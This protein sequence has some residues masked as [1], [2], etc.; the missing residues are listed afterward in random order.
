M[1]K[2]LF[3]LFFTVLFLSSPVVLNAQNKGEVLHDFSIWKTEDDQVIKGDYVMIPRW[4]DYTLRSY[5]DYIFFNTVDGGLY[6]LKNND[7]SF[8]SQVS[9][10]KGEVLMVNED[11]YLSVKDKMFGSQGVPSFYDYQNHKIWT[12]KYSSVLLIEREHRVVCYQNKP[13]SNQ[14]NSYRAFNYSNGSEMWSFTLSHKYHYPWFEMKRYKD[15]PDDYYVIAD[16]LVKI[17]LKTG[18]TV[19]QPFQGGVV[20]PMKSRF[21]LV[22]NSNPSSSSAATE[23]YSSCF[24]DKCI[25]TGTHSQFLR[26]KDRLFIA[27]AKIVYCYDLDLNPIWKTALPEGYGANSHLKRIGDELELTCIGEAFEGGL[28]GRYGRVFSASYDLTSGKQKSLIVPAIS[29]KITAALSVKEGTYWQS[30]N[31]LFYSAKGDTAVTKINWKPKDTREYDAEVTSRA[32]CDTIYTYKDHQLTP[33]VSDD[34]TLIVELYGQ[35]VYLVHQDGSYEKIDAYDAFFKD[36]KMVYSSNHVKGKSDER[37]VI[38]DPETD[39]VLFSFK[40][41]VN[42]EVIS[43]IEQ[44][45][46]LLRPNGI[47]IIYQPKK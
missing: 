22:K 42:D 41:S 18:K 29:K 47:G 30:D 34:N 32:M 5:S 7:L 25:L 14:P 23:M 2:Y 33:I 1:M 45:V 35:D 19:R 43:T 44:R 13:F 37:Y 26:V 17:N 40:K 6:V 31:Q 46:Y 15:H 3:K 39:K 38:T 24:T 12:G 9:A 20:E 10:P 4:S 11:G 21:S 28:Y 36:A 8:V 27:D 16:E